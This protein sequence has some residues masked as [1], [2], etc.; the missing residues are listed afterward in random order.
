[1]LNSIKKLAKKV[2]KRA[3]SVAKQARKAFDKMG[4]DP[5]FYVDRKGRRINKTENDTVF[6]KNRDGVRNYK[7]VASAIKKGAKSPKIAITASTAKTVPK[8]IR[9]KK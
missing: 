3:M 1:M 4:A 6:T 8:K 5:T 9:P 7:P 2:Q